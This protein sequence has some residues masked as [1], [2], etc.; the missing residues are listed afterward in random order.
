MSTFRKPYPTQ[1]YTPPQRPTQQPTG[2]LQQPGKG[3]MGVWQQPIEQP[4]QPY[5]S[6][7]WTPPAQVPYQGALGQPSGALG[8]ILQTQPGQQPQQGL[9][10]MSALMGILQ[11][12]NRR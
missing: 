11:M 10:Q 4:R 7:S 5:P 12:L 6:G 2:I 8:G 3:G 1:T 9:G